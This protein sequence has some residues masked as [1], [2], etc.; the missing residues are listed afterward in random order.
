VVLSLP[1]WWRGSAWLLDACL[2]GPAAGCAA[3]P[4]GGREGGR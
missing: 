3:E 2:A 1:L 4:A